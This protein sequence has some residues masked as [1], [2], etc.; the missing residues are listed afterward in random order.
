MDGWMSGCESYEKRSLEASGEKGQYGGN[1]IIMGI[2]PKY[3]DLR[4]AVV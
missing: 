1:C 2:S 3:N 4:I